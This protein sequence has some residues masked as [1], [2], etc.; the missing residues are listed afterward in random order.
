MKPG[1]NVRDAVIAV[2]GGALVGMAFPPVGYWAC[3]LVSQAVF[4]F[5]IRSKSAAEARN[6]GLIYGLAYAG[7]TM[8]WL[9]GVFGFHA[10]SLVALYAAYFGVLAHLVGMTREF[11]A[12]RR[13]VLLAVFAVGVEWLRGDAWYIRFPWYTA[14]H[15]LAA[16]PLMIM[17]A[18]YLG[19]YGLSFSIWLISGLGCFRKPAYWAA[20]LLLPAA[21][22]LIVGH[23]AP[24]ASALVVQAEGVDS[25]QSVIPSALS[26]TVSLVVLPEYSYFIEPELVL[27][28]PNGPS[29]LA[30]SLRSPTIFGAVDGVFGDS[31]FQNVAVVVDSSCRILGRFPKQR[32]V[33]LFVDGKPG[34]VC[35]VFPVESG[36]LGVAICY[37]FDAPAVA[38]SLVRQGATVFVA[39]TFDAM[40]WGRIQ[41]LNHELLLRLRAVEFER[42]AIRS[43]SSGRSESIDPNGHSSPEGVEIG[44]KGYAVVPYAHVTTI[45]LA[46][47]AALLGPACAAISVLVWMT[48]IVKRRRDNIARWT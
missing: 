46:A 5:L 44:Q 47:Y 3:A 28:T 37:D 11:S 7:S 1:I 21:G 25:V 40:S 32:P 20:I 10:V 14:P 12:V 39:P 41:H 34:L 38:A 19:T 23:F 24:A 2:L 17:P 48:L 42:W 18:R 6:I 31:S 29:L 33:P 8:H 30:R 4:V 9:F 36:V 13:S 43:A 27:K 16:A 26:E 45:T 35:P 15:A 22:Y